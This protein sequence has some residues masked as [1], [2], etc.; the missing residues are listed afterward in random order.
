MLLGHTE[1]ENT[2]RHPDVEVGDALTLAEG[3]EI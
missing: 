1:I 2:V 3:T